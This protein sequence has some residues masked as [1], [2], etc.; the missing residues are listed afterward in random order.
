MADECVDDKFNFKN[1]KQNEIKL[2]AA[3]ITEKLVETE[4]FYTNMLGFG[5]TLENE[6][7]LLRYTPT[8][9]AQISFLLSNYPSQQL[10]F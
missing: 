9:E 5:V 7:Y 3:I 2:N 8:K 10:L 6:F 4:A 1:S